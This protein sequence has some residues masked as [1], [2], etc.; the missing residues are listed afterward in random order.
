MCQLYIM[1]TYHELLSFIKSLKSSDTMEVNGN[2]MKGDRLK[3]FLITNLTHPQN[4]DLTAFKKPKEI[5]TEQE[6]PIKTK[7]KKSKTS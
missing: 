7:S 3:T 5:A 2:V 6:Q 4:I 1:A